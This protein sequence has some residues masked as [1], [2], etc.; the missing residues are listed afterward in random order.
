LN[1]SEDPETGQ[2]KAPKGL[3]V[4]EFEKSGTALIKRSKW[5]AKSASCS[6]NP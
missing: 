2:T 1:A 6:A 3:K 5:L 4:T